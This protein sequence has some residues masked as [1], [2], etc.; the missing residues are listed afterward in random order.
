M[1]APWGAPVGLALPVKRNEICTVR[2]APSVVFHG[3]S[4]VK[5]GWEPRKTSPDA[6]GRI[7][8]AGDPTRAM[9]A[10]RRRFRVPNF[11][12]RFRV[13]AGELFIGGEAEGSTCRQ[14]AQ[15]SF[16]TPKIVPRQVECV[17]SRITNATNERAS[18]RGGDFIGEAGQGGYTK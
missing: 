7:N 4:L 12:R 18:R 15:R 2:V 6:R 14:L 5:T 16:V 17:K 1:C 10:M 9:P 13:S 3:F 8:D 11:P